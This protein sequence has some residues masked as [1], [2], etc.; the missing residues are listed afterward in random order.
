M[1]RTRFPLITS[2]P[3]PKGQ[4]SDFVLSLCGWMDAGE[5]YLMEALTKNGTCTCRAGQLL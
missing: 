2:P 1:Q 3:L 5:G 4:R